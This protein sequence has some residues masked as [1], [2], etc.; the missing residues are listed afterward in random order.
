MRLSAHINPDDHQEFLDALAGSGR[1]KLWVRLASIKAIL[2]F[3]LLLAGLMTFAVV[4]A[5]ATHEG[6]LALFEEN[7][8]VVILMVASLLSVPAAAAVLWDTGP[9]L[10]LLRSDSKG[11]IDSAA[12]RDGVNVGKV[13]FDFAENTLRV[14]LE[15]VQGGYSWRVFSELMETDN[16]LCL[17]FGK[18]SALVIPKRAFEGEAAL[19][20]FRALFASR[21][22]AVA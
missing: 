3:I 11:K 16:L 10:R 6:G 17:K 7:P 13:H 15:L 2:V 19:H 5:H 12:L 21:T 8:I 9:T 18:G 4:L 1:R 22:G 14:G 20:A